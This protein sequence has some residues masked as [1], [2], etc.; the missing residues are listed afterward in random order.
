M[1]VVW[2]LC[3]NCCEDVMSWLVSGCYGMLVVWM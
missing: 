2:M 3:Y 1:I